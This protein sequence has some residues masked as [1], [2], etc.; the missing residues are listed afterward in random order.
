MKAALNLV[1]ILAALY[2]LFCLALYFF[3]SKLIFFPQKISDQA[4]AG[5]RAVYPSAEIRLETPDGK[6][7]HGWFLPSEGDLKKDP[8]VIYFGGNAEEVSGNVLDPHRLKSIS[9]LFINYR[10]YGL[11]T[12]TPSAESFIADALL[13]YD[14]MIERGFTPGQIIVVGRSLGTGVATALARQRAV[15]KILLVSPFDS[16]GAVARR[17]YPFA[18]VDMLL[19]HAFDSAE[20]AKHIEIP[21]KM[22]LAENDETVPHEHSQKLF[23]AW[24]GPKEQILIPGAVHNNLHDFDFYWEEIIRFIRPSKP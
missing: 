22:I 16:L 21:L 11:S 20:R 9:S 7:L 17:H 14:A 2:A 13:I 4:L 5:I 18:P 1:L 10:G 15:A 19:R 8:L 3:Q 23:Q 6:I 12:G 24:K